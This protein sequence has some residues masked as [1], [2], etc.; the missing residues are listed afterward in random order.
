MIPQCKIPIGLNAALRQ[1]GVSPAE[2][3]RRAQLPSHVL[4]TAGERLGV[5]AY[6]ALWRAIG[7]VSAEPNIGIKLAQSVESGFTEPL[8]LALLSAA[9]VASAID[10]ISSYKR[11]L[12]PEDLEVHTDGV[13]GEV[14]LAYEWPEVDED[15]PGVLTDVELAFIVEMFRRATKTPE[16][17]PRSLHLR[18]TALAAGAAHA[19]FFGCPLHLGA[20]GNAIVFAGA[21]LRRPFVT[22][23]PQMLNALL[24]YLQAN[25]LA[26]PRSAIARVR[27]VIA[28]QLRGKR[29]T[30]DTVGKELAMSSRT[31]QR[32]LHENSTSF[33]RLLDEVRSEHA[34][35]YLTGTAFSDSEVAF[36]LGFEDPNSFYRAFR[37]WQGMA[38]GEFRR[39]PQAK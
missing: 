38:P 3:L 12:S 21:D 23:N 28:E 16:L 36:L 8:F 13:T 15:P 35:G 22:H 37:S 5:S 34:R 1:L 27:S 17:R 39:R 26:S 2:V 7:V 11:M 4:D 32:L 10:I 33:R 30:V 31:L 29:P 18:R 20:S 14:T 25:T 6:F 24:P 9:D 19:T